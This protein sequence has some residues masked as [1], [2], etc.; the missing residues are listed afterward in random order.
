M[1][2]WAVCDFVADSV[3]IDSIATDCVCWVW[4]L[5]VVLVRCVYCLRLLLCVCYVI[6]TYCIGLCV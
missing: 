4:C 6:V 2:C 5:P 1:V 3:G